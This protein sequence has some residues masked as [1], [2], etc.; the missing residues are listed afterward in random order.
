MSVSKGTYEKVAIA[1]SEY[2]RD[3]SFP[4]NYYNLP[5][6]NAY[7]KPTCLHCKHFKQEHCVLDLF[8]KINDRMGNNI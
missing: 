5:S 6:T 2:K 8:D 7:E 3:Y 1:C 4:G